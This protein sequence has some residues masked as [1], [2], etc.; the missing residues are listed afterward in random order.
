[1]TARQWDNLHEVVEIQ[2]DMICSV[3][4]DHF[5]GLLRLVPPEWMDSA[6]R[7]SHVT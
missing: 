4:E 7:E 2:K 3:S 6:L 1:M 5:E